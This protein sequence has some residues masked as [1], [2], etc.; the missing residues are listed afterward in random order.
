MMAFVQF[1]QGH[2]RAGWARLKQPLLLAVM[3]S[4]LLATAAVAQGSTKF[5]QDILGQLSQAYQHFVDSGQVWALLIGAV[6][7]YLL[8]SL[9]AY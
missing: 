6:L 8:R 3:S 7:G 9:T 4:L 2:A 5:D 1:L